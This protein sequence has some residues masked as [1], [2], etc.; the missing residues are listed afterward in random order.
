MTVLQTLWAPILLSSVLVFFAS[1]VLHMLI[2][3]HRDEM[4]KLPQEE[5]ILDALRPFDIPPGDY[6]AP[7]CSGPKEMAT[8]EFA[9]RQRKGPIVFIH[10]YP[11]DPSRMGR[12]L[13]MWFAYILV[14][15]FFAAYVACHA[16]RVGASYL[17]V[18]RFAGTTAFLGY[19]AALWQMSIWYGRPWKTTLKVTVDGI[20]FAGLTAGTFGWLWPR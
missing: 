7:H 6:I 1:F 15:S 14:I 12:S 10:R 5:Q 19:T 9:E 13:M 20:I 16:L 8:P 2:P 3:W 11:H 4:K 18:F 17:H